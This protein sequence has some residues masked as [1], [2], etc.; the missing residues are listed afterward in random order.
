MEQNN[1]S[2]LLELCKL[3]YKL[4]HP[5]YCEPCKE[6]YCFKEQEVDNTSMIYLNKGDKIVE[7]EETIYD[8]GDNTY[9]PENQIFN[10]YVY[11]YEFKYSGWYYVRILDRGID[12][13]Y[14]SIKSKTMLSDQTDWVMHLDNNDFKITSFNGADRY[15]DKWIP[16]PQ[17]PH[18]P[19][20]QESPLHKIKIF[21]GNLDAISYSKLNDYHEITLLNNINLSKYAQNK[22]S[23]C[24]YNPKKNHDQIKLYKIGNIGYGLNEYPCSYDAFEF[25][26]SSHFD[27]CFNYFN[28]TDEGILFS[29]IQSSYTM[30]VGSE[31]ELIVE[32]CEQCEPLNEGITIC[33]FKTPLTTLVI[34]DC[35]TTGLPKFDN[36]T[37]Q[38]TEISMIAVNIED[39][40]SLQNGETSEKIRIQH[41]LTVAIQPTVPIQKDAQKITKLDSEMLKTCSTF[42]NN[43]GNLIHSFLKSFDGGV[44]IIAHNG[45]EFDFPILKKSLDKCETKLNYNIYCADSLQIFRD[46]EEGKQD[47]II[48]L[49]KGY[50]LQQLFKKS[51]DEN[52][53]TKININPH[54][55][56]G[57]ALMLLNC[58]IAKKK[59]F[60]PLLDEY[61]D[62]FSF[63]RYNKN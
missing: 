54:T 60:I 13:K 45:L 58:I 55:S 63:V 53:R 25:Q 3:E 35:E 56:E 48:M 43:T 14:S 8:H 17:P 59:Q 29:G 21:I 47:G 30:N 52:V 32:E 4:T 7:F 15:D 37:T 2:N 12:L 39:I 18:K 9:I 50:T 40:M 22:F 41:K 34:F 38:I 11:D 10:Y 61:R 46:I 19:L 33:D 44:C 62:L 24:E 27:K 26:S 23:M 6:K 42:N 57:D 31:I 20:H 36:N 28:D 16:L 51:F 5:I 1:N 49:T